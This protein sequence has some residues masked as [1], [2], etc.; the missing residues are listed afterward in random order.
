[1]RIFNVVQ[2]GFLQVADFQTGIHARNFIPLESLFDVFKH[3]FYRRASNGSGIAAWPLFLPKQTY[4]A[5]VPYFVSQELSIAFL[6]MWRQKC[7]NI[8]SIHKKLP[9]MPF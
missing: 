9:P 4:H 8:E 3:H 1:M 5:L 6:A 2:F 7:Y